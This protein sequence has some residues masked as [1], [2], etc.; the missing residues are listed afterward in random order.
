MLGLEVTSVTNE[1]IWKTRK[2]I[3]IFR[4]KVVQYVLFSS[5]YKTTS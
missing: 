2:P 1:K 5:Q 3:I 4:I